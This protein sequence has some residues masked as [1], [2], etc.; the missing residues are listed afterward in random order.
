MFNYGFELVGFMGMVNKLG[1]Y[2][3]PNLWILTI[4]VSMTL[5]PYWEIGF[6]YEKYGIELLLNYYILW[7]AS[8]A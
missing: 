1:Y 2:D 5:T 7:K 8:E 3:F 4:K 6:K